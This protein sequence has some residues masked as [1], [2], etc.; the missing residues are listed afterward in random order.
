MNIIVTGGKTLVRCLLAI[1]LWGHASPARAA[2]P[3]IKE[4]EAA[5]DALNAAFKT[6]DAATIRALMTPDHVAITPYG[7]LQRVKDQLRT[8]PE[9]KYEVYSAGPMSATVSGD[10][11]VILNYT[12][13]TKGTY[14]GNPLASKSLVSSVWTKN[15]GRWQELLYQE[16]PVDDR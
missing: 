13:K 11:C 9:L 7:G 5:A 15:D 10:D 6:H 14:R 8:L 4:V 16:T 2:D 12:L 3:L 1:L